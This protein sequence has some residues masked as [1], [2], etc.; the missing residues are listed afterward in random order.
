[1]AKSRM[2][3]KMA[4]LS[5]QIKDALQENGGEVIEAPLE[6]AGVLNIGR[7]RDLK[8]DP[9]GPKGFTHSHG[10]CRVCALSRP[11]RLRVEE[12]FC[13]WVSTS[14]IAKDL[15]LRGFPEVKKDSVYRHCS[16][17]GFD[18]KRTANV[19]RAIS[20]I[21]DKGMDSLDEGRM[22]IR[23]NDLITAMTLLARLD[24]LLSDNQL[25]NNIL[26][27]NSM[28]ALEEISQI[29]DPEVLKERLANTIRLL[30]DSG[31]IPGGEKPVTPEQEHYNRVKEIVQAK[32]GD[33][34]S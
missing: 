21:V 9:P 1:M 30:Q 16:A 20:R 27:R 6:Q 4:D 34:A 23:A 29:K 24:G 22:I 15:M 11:I 25:T 7:K 13:N 2:H 5:G 17:L 18:L 8:L 26:I 32:V 10:R 12:D 33:S 19:K 31:V 14:E 28:P 3:Q